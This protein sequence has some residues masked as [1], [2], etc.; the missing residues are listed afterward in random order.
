M[1]FETI[2]VCRCS[3]VSNFRKAMYWMRAIA[4]PALTQVTDDITK[5]TVNRVHRNKRLFIDSTH[6]IQTRFWSVKKNNNLFIHTFWSRVVVEIAHFIMDTLE[7]SDIMCENKGHMVS[8]Q[9]R[10]VSKVHHFLSL[11]TA[12]LTFGLRIASHFINSFILLLLF[13]LVNE[14]CPV[15]S[16]WP[17][18]ILCSKTVKLAKW[19]SSVAATLNWW[20][21]NALSTRLV[22]VCS[23]RMA[24]YIDS[25]VSNWAKRAS[26]PI[27]SKRTTQKTCLK[28]N[29]RCAAGTGVRYISMGPC[30]ISI[31]NE[32]QASKYHCKMFL[33]VQLE[34]T[35]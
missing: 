12:R 35:R 24:H 13:C 8:N 26:W 11:C 20:I 21:S 31:V 33:N 18:K 19:I 10:I 28:R 6:F 22:C 27:F 17:T 25:P 1:G 34:R 3:K 29:C 23:Q 7:Y 9:F 32:R 16:N 5:Y 30:W 2:Q 14:R 15:E 4:C